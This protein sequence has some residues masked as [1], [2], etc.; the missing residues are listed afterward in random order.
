MLV[1]P[2]CKRSASEQ[3]ALCDTSILA[4]R[5]KKL[6]LGHEELVYPEPRQV[7]N[8]GAILRRLLEASRSRRDLSKPA[9][10]AERKKT[11]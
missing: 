5:T 3:A 2:T 9:G 7:A 1:T 10:K 11:C 6:R 4:K 8:N